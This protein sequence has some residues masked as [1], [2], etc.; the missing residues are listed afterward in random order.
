MAVGAGRGGVLELS[1]CSSLESIEG[2]HSVKYGLCESL[3]G[4]SELTI[5][6]FS[7]RR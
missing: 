3:G 5:T 7:P 6:S 4:R 2:I 1:I